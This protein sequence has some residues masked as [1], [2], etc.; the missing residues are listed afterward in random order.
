MFQ[1]TVVA[2]NQQ[3]NNTHTSGELQS[4]NNYGGRMAN[5]LVV[6]TQTATIGSGVPYGVYHTVQ[7]H[8]FQDWN[9]IYMPNSSTACA[10][11]S[12]ANGGSCGPHIT[13]ANPNIATPAFCTVD[14]AVTMAQ[15]ITAFTPPVGSPAR[16]AGYPLFIT[17]FDIA[18][19]ARPLA[20]TLGGTLID[21]G[22]IQVT[23]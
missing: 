4:S 19:T 7:Q 18:G 23:P 12:T 15:A 8:G 1:N 3:T 2:N 21:F 5:N 10:A 17:P 11:A 20:A 13:S 16:A 22:A 14:A 6:A 9:L